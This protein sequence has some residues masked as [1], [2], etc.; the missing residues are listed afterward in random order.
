MDNFSHCTI[1][2]FFNHK[3]SAFKEVKEDICSQQG[4]ISLYIK[5]GEK[6][7]AEMKYCR[8]TG[9]CLGSSVTITTQE[10]IAKVLAASL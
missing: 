3:D 2:L 1:N 10:T 7:A 6:W 9:S 4:R 8:E 5:Y